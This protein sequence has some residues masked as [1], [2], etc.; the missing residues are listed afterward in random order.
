[1]VGKNVSKIQL[2]DTLFIVTAE[3][4]STAKETLK[5]KLERLIMSHVADAK[6]CQNNGENQ[7]AMCENQS[8]Y[9]ADTI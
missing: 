2:G 9:R 5:K 8:E 1:M 4:S 7:L 6:S 3:Y